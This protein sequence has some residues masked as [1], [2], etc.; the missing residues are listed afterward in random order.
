[1]GYSLNQR[2][3]DILAGLCLDGF[4]LSEENEAN[5]GVLLLKGP[6]YGENVDLA[7]N[8]RIEDHIITSMSIVFENDSSLWAI[9][10]ADY[11]IRKMKVEARYGK[12]LKTVE[13]F[14]TPFEENDG[15]E[16][17]A[18]TKEFA[19]WYSLYAIEGGT[20]CYAINVF[21]GILRPTLTII[22]SININE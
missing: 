17:A 6:F 20:I 15:M 3:D 16:L 21:N 13:Y 14:D 2:I 12:P 1:M 4:S 8:Y 5:S 7:I 9:I 18:F 11:E 10:N 19:K 22:D